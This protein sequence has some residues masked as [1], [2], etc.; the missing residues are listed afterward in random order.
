MIRSALLW[1][2]LSVACQRVAEPPPA[3]EESEQQSR[4]QVQRYVF[5]TTDGEELSAESMHGRVS[6]LL[7]VATFDLAS[8]LAAKQLNQALHK[9][10]PRINA[11]AV[12]LEAAKYAP[13]AD[14]FK[15]SLSLS[16][17]VAIADLQ[18]LAQNSTLGE[19]RSV[20]TLIIFDAQGREVRRQYGAFTSEELETWLTSAR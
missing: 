16:Y 20:P 13:L 9:H 19:V 8:Q 14:V 17:P 15:S 2:L 5:G 12:V 10:A 6:V 7:F 18:T 11:G 1:L 3:P 4:G